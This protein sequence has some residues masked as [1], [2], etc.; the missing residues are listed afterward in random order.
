M[1]RGQEGRDATPSGGVE[2]RL[3]HSVH[4]AG[5]QQSLGQHRPMGKWSLTKV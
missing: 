1:R 4:A 3:R 2:G 5:A